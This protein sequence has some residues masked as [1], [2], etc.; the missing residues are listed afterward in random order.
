MLENDVYLSMLQ[1]L[2]CLNYLQASKNAA[3]VLK[4]EIE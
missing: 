3:I 1:S 2:D 4:K